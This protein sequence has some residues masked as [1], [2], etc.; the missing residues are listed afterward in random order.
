MGARSSIRPGVS[1]VESMQVYQVKFI[2]SPLKTYI[3][4]LQYSYTSMI[5]LKGENYIEVPP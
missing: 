4:I 3:V 2:N 1:V 5:L